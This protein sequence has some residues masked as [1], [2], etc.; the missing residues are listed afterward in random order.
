[1]KRSGRKQSAFTAGELAASVWERDDFKYFWAGLREAVNVDVTP[2]G[3]L[4]IR[5][6]LRREALLPPSASRA[7][8]FTASNGAVYDII[9]SDGVF[10]IWQGP[11]LMS[12]VGNDYS[13]AMLGELVMAQQLDTAILTHPLRPPRRLLHY[14]PSSW[15]LDDVPLNGIPLFD[16][17]A[18]YTNGVSAE[19]DIELIGFREGDDP[20]NESVIFTLTVTGSET[21][22]LRL[23]GPPD[24]PHATLTA[25]AIRDA[26]L[27]LPNMSA[28]VGV[29]VIDAGLDRYRVYFGGAANAGDAWAVSGRVVNKADAAVVCVKRVAGV[30]PGEPII[31]YVRGWP[32][33]AVFYQQRLMLG[34]LV[35]QPNTYMVSRTGDYFNFDER[36]DTAAGA[37]RVPMDIPGGEIIRRMVA[38]RDLL[39]LTNSAEYSIADREFSKTKPPVHVEASRNGLRGN[40]VAENEGAV[41][42]AFARGGGVGEM[43]W[44]DVSGNYA[45]GDLGLLAPHLVANVADLAVRGKTGSQQG[46]RIALVRDD[47]RLVLGTL[48]REQEVTAFSRVGSEGDFISV[49]CNWRNELKV[50]VQR[51]L[52]NGMRSLESFEEGLLLDDAQSFTISPPTSLIAPLDHGDGTILWVIGDGDVFGPLTVSGGAVTLPR[53]VSNVTY[54]R[55][56]P[57]W[58]STLPLSR[59]V[60]PKTVVTGF[61]RIHTVHLNLEDTTSVAISVNGGPV[62]DVD[63]FRAVDISA[64]APELSQ[65]FTGQRTIRDLR[66]WRSDPYVTI[67]QLRPGRLT[68]KSITVEAAL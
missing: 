49:A 59:E 3:G 52:I 23:A 35:S 1:M 65:G 34:G 15:V 2:Q 21:A 30:A 48:L 42:F 25:H 29:G 39:I 37:F 8:S 24:A 56:I 66:G 26:I 57:P 7:F 45:T 17:G 46:N 40:G 43:R 61:G 14:G 32:R 47:H 38:A 64:G 11:T 60:G 27:E 68:L 63:L 67:T 33:C 13:S 12:Q 16:Y 20:K 54:G 18:A 4:T 22:S 36:N 41:L 50:I 51:P 5:P 58:I 28:G 31:S 55:W 19:W 62:R 9:A 53:P 6:G 10:S 44:T